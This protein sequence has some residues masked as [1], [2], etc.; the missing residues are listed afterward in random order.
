[1]FIFRIILII[2][3]CSFNLCSDNHIKKCSIHSDG[4]R[5][6]P[7]TDTNALSPT[8]YFLIHYDLEGTH[9]PSQEDLN[10][11]G[12]PDYVD[13]V[14]I[15]ADSSRYILADVLGFLPVP[16]DLDG[17]YDIYIQNMPSGYYG[18]NFQD[19]TIEN[20]SYIKIDNNYGTGDFYTIG[21]KAMQVTV[22]H[23]FFHAVQRAYVDHP[24]DGEKFFWEM[25]STWIEDI[26]VPDSNDY[27]FG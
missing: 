16:D 22:A 20:A 19:D 18:V 24:P 11:N 6:R 5:V 2:L 10:Q 27:L 15:I 25:S 23:E 17:L 7:T 3:F 1:M 14:G 13:E 12:I 26:I 8:G 21:I 4:N 9:S